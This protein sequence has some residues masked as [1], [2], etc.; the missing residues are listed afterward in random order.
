[1][2]Y[3][4]LAFRP[5]SHGWWLICHQ[6]INI[7]DF[8]KPAPNEKLYSFKGFFSSLKCKE[9]IKNGL[10]ALGW[11]LRIKVALQRIFAKWN[12]IFESYCDYLRFAHIDGIGQQLPSTDL[13]SSDQPINL[14]FLFIDW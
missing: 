5:H 7:E 1:M 12:M 10:E 2:F 6:L 3:P 4:G 9:L 13:D 11:L 14:F 8:K